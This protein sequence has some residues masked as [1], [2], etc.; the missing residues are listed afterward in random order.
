MDPCPLESIPQLVLTVSKT[1]TQGIH[2]KAA[3]DHKT[4]DTA[5]FVKNAVTAPFHEA[6]RVGSETCLLWDVSALYTDRI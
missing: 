2:D 1:G 6:I 3:D 5:E 4:S